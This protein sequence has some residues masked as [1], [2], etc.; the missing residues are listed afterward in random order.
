MADE[1]H[2]V[3]RQ[4]DPGGPC[5]GAV[6]P[7]ELLDALESR[8]TQVDHN[9]NALPTLCFD[10]ARDFAARHDYS[11]TPLKG[12]PIAIKDLLP[13]A[14]VRTTWGS[15]L[16]ENHVPEESD[17]LVERLEPPARSFTPNQIPLN[18]VQAPIPSMTFLVSHATL[19]T[20]RFH[21]PAHQAALPLHWQLVQ[22]GSQAVRTSAGPS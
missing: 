14:G 2:P 6:A 19:G 17:L 7:S 4:T 20:R 9:V 8:I 15:M 10:R 5:P 12:L 22:P 11:E 13:V 16:H 3:D 1:T 18:S 21:A